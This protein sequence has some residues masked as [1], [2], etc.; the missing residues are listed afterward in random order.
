M[1]LAWGPRSTPPPASETSARPSPDCSRGLWAERQ[2]MP[3][4]TQDLRHKMW[5]LSEPLS[6]GGR[7]HSSL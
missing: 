5:V 7:P 4:A 2:P 3:E 1:A 6:L